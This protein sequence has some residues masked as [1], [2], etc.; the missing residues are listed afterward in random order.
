M[1]PLTARLQTIIEK[2]ESIMG[3]N[4]NAT[5]HVTNNTS[6]PVLIW[7]S[8]EY[9]SDGAQIWPP[10][11]TR[12]RVI[13]PGQSAGPLQVGFNTGTF[14]TGQDYWFCAY[15]VMQE[16]QPKIVYSTEGSLDSPIKKCTLSSKDNGATEYFSISS[17]VFTMSELTGPC[18]TD[19]T[20]GNASAALA[21]G[22]QRV[23]DEVPLEAASGE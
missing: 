14:Y 10:A 22:Q 12:Q 23:P 5:I 8:H 3:F 6:H 2:K 20:A 11:G 13:K 4:S 16:G 9:S 21:A 1:P 7:F 15:Q 17:S 18:Y 19:L